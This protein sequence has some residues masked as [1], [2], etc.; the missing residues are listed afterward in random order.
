[1]RALHSHTPTVTARDGRGLE[2][3]I[4]SY[5]RHP[6]TPEAT[7][8]R[9]SVQHYDLAGRPEKLFDPR[10]SD[11]PCVHHIHTL[12]G[13]IALTGSV[14]AGVS[15]SLMDAAGRPSL[16]YTGVG[17]DSQVIREWEYEPS[18]LPGRVLSIRE[19][20][21]E[22]PATVSERFVWALQSPE[23]QRHN[24]CG[25]CVRHYDPAGLD[26]IDSVGLCGQLRSTTRRLAIATDNVDWQ[27]PGEDAWRT[28]LEPDAFTTRTDHDSTGN[29]VAIADAMGHR[30]RMAYDV[31][32]QLTRS[33]IA[34]AGANEQPVISNITYGAS[35]E[36]RSEYLAN[37]VSTEHGHEPETLRLTRLISRQGSRTL[38]DLNHEYDPM[39]NV[40]HIR[41]L[42]Q[43][44][45]YWRNQRVSAHSAFE[46]DTLYQMTHSTGREMASNATNE[47]VATCPPPV[48]D[49][50]LTR[51]DRNY[52]YDRGG[53][54]TRIRH[55]AP[56]ANHGF[57]LDMTVSQYKN[58]AVIA[59]LTDDPGQV[60][61]LFSPQGH[62]RYLQPG[63]ALHWNSRG[64]L[65]QVT[66]VT[67]LGNDSDIESYR[68]AADARRIRK[69]RRAHTRNTVVQRTVVYL[70][71]LEIRT[72]TIDGVQKDC[73]HIVTLGQ[74]RVMH[75]Q[76]GLP[77]GIDND[78]VRYSLTNLVGSHELE[79]DC[80]GALISR[81]EFYPYGGRALWSTPTPGA[82]DLKIA[83]YSGKERDATGLYYYGYRYYQPWAGRWLSSDPAGTADGPNLYRMVRNNPVSMIDSDGRVATPACLGS[84]NNARFDELIDT[85]VARLPMRAIKKAIQMIW[86]GTAPLSEKNS[87]LSH[88]TARMNS[89]YATHIWFDSAIS[90]HEA[91]LADMRQQFDSSAIRLQDVRSA[92]WLSDARKHPS[93]AL[94]ERATTR[95]KYA[96]ASDLLRLM[97]L[98]YEGGVYKDID[99]RQKQ[100]FGALEFPGGLGVNVESKMAGYGEFIGNSPIAAVE[101]H[102]V[103]QQ[104]LEGAVARVEGGEEDIFRIAGPRAFTTT[105]YHHY[106]GMAPVDFN[107]KLDLFTAHKRSLVSSNATLNLEEIAALQRPYRQIRGLGKFIANGSDHSWA[108]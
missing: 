48:T 63:Q 59:A 77:E 71:N 29:P 104:M 79:L 12:G 49:D 69:I 10:L 26:Q 107:L 2:V 75:W 43:P 14:D 27:G 21:A 97:L 88:E 86:I 89:D 74:V 67:R 53:N 44:E 76:S 19:G 28:L 66:P 103:I 100:P 91:A 85:E 64:E 3:C 101:G 105:L 98:K 92:R 62:Q 45:R 108:R 5:H 94:Y 51:Y 56:A 99:D 96:E 84:A 40:L 25:H 52:S 32:G 34:L 4:L 1:M 7:D 70:P 38:Q 39:G 13:A 9:R 60:D 83:R 6:G 57:T 46:Y 50:S 30:Q 55:T 87:A 80:R 81:E 47:W 24:L 16:L 33:W 17:S 41:D 106:R 61:A 36:K 11:T 42:A 102:P 54:L 90:G 23:E 18:S 93:F 73:L 58:R 68:Y 72:T 20:L 95:G 8:T 15:I 78:Q 82:A 65:S 22:Q 35:G 31:T 37:G